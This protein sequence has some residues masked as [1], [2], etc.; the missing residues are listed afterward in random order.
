MSWIEPL[1]RNYIGRSRL[2]PC[3]PRIVFLLGF[4]MALNLW[5]QGIM[6]VLSSGSG[7]PLVIGRGTGGARD[8]YIPSQTQG[9]RMRGTLKSTLFP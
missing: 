5:I 8:Q 6:G 3:G 9:D 4:A 7:Q 1:I 2:L